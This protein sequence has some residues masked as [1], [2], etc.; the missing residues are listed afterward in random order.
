MKSGCRFVKARS[1]ALLSLHI[2]LHYHVGSDL[3]LDQQ[4]RLLDQFL[5]WPHLEHLTS[6]A[7][8]LY[9]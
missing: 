9:N 7:E 2:R 1:T 3:L 5:D 8:L 4:A 6:E